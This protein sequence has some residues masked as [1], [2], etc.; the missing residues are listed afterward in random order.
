[1]LKK[2]IPEKK[3]DSMALMIVRGEV[4]WYTAHNRLIQDYLDDKNYPAFY[5]EI[6]AQIEDKP[7]KISTYKFG[8]DNLLD[9]KQFNPAGNILHKLHHRYPTFY[10]AKRLG[11]VYLE[12]KNFN[13]SVKYLN[14]SLKLSKLD[15]SVYF[16]LSEAFFELKQFDEA[17]VNLEK[18]LQLDDNYPNAKRIRESLKQAQSGN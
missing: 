15:P 10:S 3:A 4:G 7:F 9:R 18:C 1:V 11:I 17:L 2:V 12:V 16:K 14:E 6:D 8:I 5:D 13:N